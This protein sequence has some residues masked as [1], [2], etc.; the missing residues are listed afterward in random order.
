MKE[1]ELPSGKRVLNL[2]L[3]KDNA[4]LSNSENMSSVS[5][6]MVLDTN[7]ICPK[8]RKPMGFAKAKEEQTYYC[9]SC[10]TC[11]PLPIQ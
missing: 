8:C 3:S 1:V 6:A 11:L 2:L 7:G 5:G 9:D 4:S 10:R